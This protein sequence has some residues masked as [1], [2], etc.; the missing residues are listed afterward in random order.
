MRNPH[1]CGWGGVSGARGSGPGR[2]GP[3]VE[4][5]R[6]YGTTLVDRMT[7]TCKN[8]NLQATSFAGGKKYSSEHRFRVRC[9]QFVSLLTFVMPLY[10]VLLYLVYKIYTSKC[11]RNIH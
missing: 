8:I 2:T 1:F 7:D 4:G 9:F 6:G 11:P 3:G 10:F 5:G